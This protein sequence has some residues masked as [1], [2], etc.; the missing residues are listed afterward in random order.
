MSLSYSLGLQDAPLI[1]SGSPVP[2]IVADTYTCYNSQYASALPH[3]TPQDHFT[4]NAFEGYPY[5]AISR[6]SRLG[7][8]DTK[9]VNE[10]LGPQDALKIRGSITP[11]YPGQMS[12]VDMD[13]MV[14]SMLGITATGG[15]SPHALRNGE[16]GDP[17]PGEYSS[18]PSIDAFMRVPATLFTTYPI[19]YIPDFDP[20]VFYGGARADLVL[21]HPNVIAEFLH[22]NVLVALKVGIRAWFIKG[23]KPRL[24]LIASEIRVFHCGG[25]QSLRRG[26]PSVPGGAAPQVGRCYDVC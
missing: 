9:P 13:L 14:T 6:R 4:F 15:A 21:H 20:T 18:S 25:P 3:T 5:R 23:N 7:P 22:E 12:V 8:L 24:Q 26:A 11:C 17:K 19:S 1:P 2:P 16:C 10:P